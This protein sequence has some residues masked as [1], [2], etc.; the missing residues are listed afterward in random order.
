M[1]LDARK[2]THENKKGTDQPVDLRILIST[3]VI[4]YMESIIANLAQC[5]ISI[6]SLVSVT[7]QAGLRLTW[8][9]TTKTGFL[10]YRQ[11]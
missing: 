8:S 9:E 6:F 5:T 1:D 11:C 2:P 10:T 3:F 7:K 4:C